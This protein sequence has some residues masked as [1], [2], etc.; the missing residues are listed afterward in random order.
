MGLVEAGSAVP[1]EVEN[2]H[3]GTPR[4]GFL[5]QMGKGAAF[6]P[7]PQ[8]ES[9][10]GF[11]GFEWRKHL[12]RRD[13]PETSNPWQRLGNGI[14][15]WH[16]WLER[17]AQVIS[18]FES[19]LSADEK[20]RAARFHFERDRNRYIVARGV[21]RRLLGKYLD[22][23]PATL[24]FTY[25]AYGKPALAETTVPSDL[26]FNLAHS[27][28][29]AVYAIALGRNVGV[30][31]EQIRPEFSGDDVARRYFSQQEVT[32]LRSLPPD[33]RALGFFQCWTRKEAYLKALGTGLQTPLD[34]FSVT[35]APSRPA[36]FQS[37]VAASWHLADFRPAEGYAAAVVYDG[38]S[39]PFE[40]FSAYLALESAG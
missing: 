30:D 11:K 9:G 36:A 29:L 10:L 37:G 12:E 35:L 39:T 24:Q 14:H 32:D 26:C 17:D 21:L 20:T 27:G 2:R 15:V 13:L 16:A 25:G 34:S 23:A 38:D 28:T 31:V 18:Q 40:C 19:I 5:T 3:S 22:R 8:A 4:L 1:Y 6:V 7:D 33:A